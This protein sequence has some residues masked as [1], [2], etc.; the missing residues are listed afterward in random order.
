MPTN[1]ENG[2]IFGY[3][4]SRLGLMG[5]MLTITGGLAIIVV[6][7]QRLTF[8]SKKQFQKF[9]Y[10][11]S[12]LLSI[13][14]TTGIIILRALGTS[15]SYTF[16]AYATRLTPLASWLAISSL[17]FAFLLARGNKF[18][19]FGKNET[20]I[21]FRITGFA[22][23]ILTLIV[24]FIATTRLGITPYN[25]GSWGKPTTPLLEWQLLLAIIL[26]LTFGELEK[27]WHWLKKDRYTFI[28]VYL[29]TC[30]LWLSQ[31]INPGF[32]ATAPRAPNFE[33]YP[34]SDALIY[35]QYAQSALVGN[36]FLWPDVPTRPLYI[37][38]I[39]WLHF[40]AGQDYNRV[41]VLQ[42]LLLAAF[43]AVLYLVGK[44]LSGRPLGIGLA[45][46]AAFRDLT[47]NIAA[48]FALN[49]TYT[50]LFFSEIPTALLL[51]LFFLIILRWMRKPLPAWYPF[52]AGGL[53]GLSTLI[54]LQSAVVLAAVIPISYFVISNHKRWLNGS[55]FI[56]LGLT[57]T[58]APWLT[59]NYLATGGIVLDNPISQS[60]VLAR[61]WGGNSGNDLIPHL[62]GEGDAQYSSRMTGMA[63]DSLR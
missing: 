29:F 10:I 56:V 40:I 17:E 63:L 2:V 30:L 20:R 44:E 57:L 31:P 1:T 21:F 11:L 8:L 47:A 25:D 37:T 18:F 12:L 22:V 24:C 39:T 5:L 53:L 23:I 7:K 61:R 6:F 60:M 14:A 54:R 48:P 62:A 49:Y 45:V 9:Y 50:K 38:L 4:A 46:L 35:A 33:I 41:I 42:T 3:S 58:I 36:G 19:N 51:S 26:S 27:R 55:I 43:P 32:F 34:F 52:L 16:G 59:R 15:S 28:L 13:L